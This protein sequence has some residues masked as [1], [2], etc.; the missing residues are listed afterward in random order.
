MDASSEKKENHIAEIFIV[1]GYIAFFCLAF[2]FVFYVLF[3][4]YVKPRSE[5]VNVFATS[6]P[7]MTPTP[8]LYLEGKSLE[9]AISDNFDD[10]DRR[11]SQ[12]DNSSRTEVKDGKLVLESLSDDRIAVADCQVCPLVDAPYF[13]QADLATDKT[14]DQ[15]VGVVFNSFTDKDEFFLFEV[16]AE[17]KTYSLYH[18]VSNTWS[19]RLDGLSHQLRS[20]PAVNTLAIY[21]NDDTVELYIN[22]EIV[23]SYTDSGHSFQDGRFGFYSG[24][25]GFKLLADNLVV[26]R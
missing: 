6:L 19:L 16:N 24:N 22:G 7:P 11:W 25:S 18:H 15:G 1:I 23:D 5:A 4:T 10:D 13:L 26:S 21:V 9:K 20:F 14:T 8:H 2:I 12:H 3:S 17:A